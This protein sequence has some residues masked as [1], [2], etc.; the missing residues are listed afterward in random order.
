MTAP[1]VENRPLTPLAAVATLA[2]HAAFGANPVAIKLA[3]PGFGPL[4]MA[5]IRFA[6]GAAVIGAVAVVT[7]RRLALS[8]R[9]AGQLL[10]VSLVFSAQ[11]G[12]FYLGM[13]R[14][15]ASRSTL[16]ASLQPFLVLALAHFFLPGDRITA[17]KLAGIALGFA[18]VAIVVTDGASW[19]GG[20]RGGDALLL[21]AI[22]LW[23]GA[24]VYSKR[25]IGGFDTF[26]FAMYPAAFS[27][28]LFAA[29]SALWDP[30]AAGAV[31]GAV[32]GALLYQILVT[33][34]LGFVAWN[35]LFKRHG[36]VAL[37]SFLF[38][39]PLAGVLLGGL[40]LGEE[41]ATVPLLVALPL[42][43]A[44]IAIVNLE[45]FRPGGRRTARSRPGGPGPPPP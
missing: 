34:S 29:A 22:A 36:A 7:G 41:V 26:A 15:L 38:V 20:L 32:A 12:L 33:A 27:A 39:Q 18:G 13:A 8:R 3:L 40:V 11:I 14:S 42:V 35:A 16:L 37:Q 1:R 25:I 28:P 4:A 6:A 9:Q 19:R 5:A 24:T 23:S 10:I 30:P 2:L 45:A 21:G 17:R 31:D 43:V 44:G